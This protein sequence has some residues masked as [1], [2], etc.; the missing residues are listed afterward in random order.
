VLNKDVHWRSRNA[1]PTVGWS[2]RRG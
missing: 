1:M 2:P